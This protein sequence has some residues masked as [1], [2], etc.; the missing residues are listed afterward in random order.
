MC[1]SQLFNGIHHPSFLN[2]P[3]ILF[4]W[5]SVD[6]SIFFPADN[7]VNLLSCFGRWIWK[8]NGVF[9]KLLY[10]LNRINTSG[11]PVSCQ[12]AT[13]NRAG[14]SFSTPAVHIY[15][16]VVFDAHINLILN[17][18][19]LTLSWE[20]EIFYGNLVEGDGDSHLFCNS[21]HVVN[22]WREWIVRAALFL[23][24]Q[25]TD[26]MPDSRLD[27]S[28]EISFL[29]HWIFWPRITTGEKFSGNNPIWQ[30]KRD[31]QYFCH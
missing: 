7:H 27:K 4:K 30:I 28:L 3:N 19:H 5:F 29:L 22:I 16:F 14:P 21:F 12:I 24:F 8:I 1:D 13:D 17:P 20:R 31:L 26:N 18:N 25:Q 11:H 9:S 6:S 10:H 23:R 15:R 2:D